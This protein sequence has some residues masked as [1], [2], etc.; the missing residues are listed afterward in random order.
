[1]DMGIST[2]SRLFRSKQAYKP[3]RVSSVG[4]SLLARTLNYGMLAVLALTLAYWTWQLVAPPAL[5]AV[6]TS[7]TVNR[8]AVA[9]IAARHWFKSENT[10]QAGGPTE[11]VLNLKL[12]GIFGSAKNRKQ[13]GFAIFQL[14]DGRQVYAMLNQEITPGLKLTGIAANAVTVEQEGLQVKIVLEEKA[15]VLD[16][17]HIKPRK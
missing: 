2:L 17:P 4:Y 13:A 6:A 9:I 11:N 16:I 12:V 7:P 10:G 1:M 15:A 5:P 14:T 8:E 3:V